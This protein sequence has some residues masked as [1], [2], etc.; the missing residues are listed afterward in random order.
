VHADHLG[1]PRKITSQA[2]NIVWQWLDKPFGD[3][4]VNQ[5]P[6]GNGV[7]FEYNL[8]FPGQY[9]DAETGLHYNWNR[10]YDPQM[11]RYITSDPIGLVGGMNTYT[12]VGG[13]P[14]NAVDPLGLRTEVTIW[15][16][17]GWGE[18]S[19]GHVSTDVNGTTFSY[20]PHGMSANSYSEYNAKNS[21]RDGMGVLIDLTPEQE[22]KLKACLG[23]DQ[24]SYSATS[25][26][27]GSPV[28]NCLKDLGINTDDQI[29]PVNLGNKLIDLGVTNGTADHPAT[30]PASGVNA[31]WAR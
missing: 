30:N 14:V 11:G 7:A 20:G 18:S 3:S 19:F 10:Y 31:P 13:S 1:S 6:D 23:K 22:A 27:C 26:N 21:F 8:R 29:L 16:P 9:F 2:G 5:D 25:N 15:H 28:Q 24:G 4:P 12:Y 17:V